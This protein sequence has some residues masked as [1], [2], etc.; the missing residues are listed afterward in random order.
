M[1]LD[2]PVTPPSRSTASTPQE[3]NP[4]HFPQIDAPRSGQSAHTALS[5]RLS[6]SSRRRRFSA[7]TS[8]PPAPPPPAPPGPR[9]TVAI[10]LC[11][12]VLVVVCLFSVCVGGWRV[13][14]WFRSCVS[15]GRMGWV[16][17]AIRAIRLIRSGDHGGGGCKRGGG[18]D[19]GF[20]LLNPEGVN[21]SH[22]AVAGG[23]DACAP[24]PP[25]M[26]HQSPAVGFG[27]I[28]PP[29]CRPRPRRLDRTEA[30]TDDADGG[31]RTCGGN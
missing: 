23:K 24:L 2:S 28:A 12:G 10:L 16:G 8:P 19:W 9:R 5:G 18:L 3:T 6:S 7:R 15:D 21:G 22:S 26:H 11:C 30:A 25:C 27:V 1:S 17:R 4:S 13:G 20:A 31:A 29:R 14:V